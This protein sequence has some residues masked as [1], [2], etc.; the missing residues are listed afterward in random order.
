[1]IPLPSTSIDPVT[2][3]CNQ[4]YAQIANQY[5]QLQQL[6]NNG[7]ALVWNNPNGTPQ[8]VV[9]TLGTQAAKVFQ[10]SSILCSTLGA[11]TGNIPSPMPPGWGATLNAD[12]T[13][14][15]T[16]PTSSTSTGV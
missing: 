4:L 11:I 10:L 9:S 8:Q 6:L 15:L 3:G 7:V 12:G 13:V 5:R 1:M 16:A 14:T 2:Q